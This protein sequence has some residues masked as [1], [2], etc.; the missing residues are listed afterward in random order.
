MISIN[1]KYTPPNNPEAA[2]RKA[3]E[4]SLR[5][6][7]K[8]INLRAQRIL[9]NEVGQI[10]GQLASKFALDYKL[11][12][13]G[14]KLEVSPRTPEY[15]TYLEFGTSP[16][17]IRPRVA[18][19]MYFEIDGVGIFSKLVHHPGN[20]AVHFIMRAVYSVVN[21]INNGTASFLSKWKFV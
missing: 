21:D 7:G 16:H 14:L 5:A 8:E 13:Q 1:I 12:R 11:T 3:C 2:T 18:R 10:S 19:A 20:R 4:G 6:I 9:A 15:W 17:I